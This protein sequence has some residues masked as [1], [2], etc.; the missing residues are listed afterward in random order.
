MPPP[1]PPHLIT[2]H[3]TINRPVANA[4][5]P[6]CGAAYQYLPPQTMKKTGECACDP[7]DVSPTGHGSTCPV[8]KTRALG[9]AVGL[10]DEAYAAF[11]ASGQPARDWFVMCEMA[12]KKTAQEHW[13]SVR[14]E[15]CRCP[16]G[17]L[18]GDCPEHGHLV[19]D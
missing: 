4:T 7:E 10:L 15:G 12:A 16:F 6:T 19:P 2:K 9:R 1:K 8:F 14:P 11:Y 18:L 3:A 5:C 17:V 13:E